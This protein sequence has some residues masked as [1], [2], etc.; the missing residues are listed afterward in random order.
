MEKRGWGVF[1]EYS[2]RRR[3]H[4][5]R[6]K[7]INF[8]VI[9]VDLSFVEL[10]IFQMVQNFYNIQSMSY[11]FIVW[12]KNW[13]QIKIGCYRIEKTK[14]DKKFRAIYVNF[15][16]R[17]TT[18][19]LKNLT[20]V[21]IS[22]KSLPRCPQILSKGGWCMEMWQKPVFRIFKYFILTAVAA[23]ITLFKNNISSLS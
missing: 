1:G 21:T 15:P 7:G 6:K 16:C 11:I 19:P 23:E 4:C 20:L 2:R 18:L 3:R 5:R 9:K 8:R 10:K 13:K 22:Q 12:K 14:N 17:T